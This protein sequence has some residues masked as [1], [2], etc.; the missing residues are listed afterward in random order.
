MAIIGIDGG[1]GGGIAR[2]RGSYAEAW[3]LEQWAKGL[4]VIV[5]AG[6]LVVIEAASQVFGTARGPMR[7]PF[8]Y[9]W[10]VAHAAG[11]CEG[12]GATVHLVPAKRWQKMMH[13][14]SM[15]EG[16]ARSIEVAK[17][18]FPLV[19]LRASER[20]KKDHDGMADALLIAEY[21]RLML[22]GTAK[23]G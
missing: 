23:A 5:S 7:A 14:G 15:A 13:M 12:L 18:L 21:G 19:S 8:A 22:N 20:C 2:L 16:K 3:P 9:V 4:G 10:S 1:V 17:R 11:Y 6:D